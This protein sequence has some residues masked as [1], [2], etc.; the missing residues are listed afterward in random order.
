[1]YKLS[2]HLQEQLFSLQT[3]ALYKIEFHHRMVITIIIN[4]ILPQIYSVAGV[5]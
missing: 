1:M 3:T 5:W 2:S 4:F